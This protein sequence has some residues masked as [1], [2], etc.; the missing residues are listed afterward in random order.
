[1]GVRLTIIIGGLVV[2][3]VLFFGSAANGQSFVYGGAPGPGTVIGYN[4]GHA[5][6]CQVSISGSTVFYLL[7]VQEGGYGYTNN[8]NL[9]AVVASACQT[10]NLVAIHVTSF[11][12]FTWDYLILYPFK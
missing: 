8:P 12:P 6:S 10:G 4:F 1:M 7:V 5:S 11:S 2:A 9:A 3:G